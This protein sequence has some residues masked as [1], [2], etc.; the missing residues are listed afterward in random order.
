MK[1]WE[2]DDTNALRRGQ[3]ATQLELARRL[4]TFAQAPL[5]DERSAIMRDWVARFGFQPDNMSNQLEHLT[6]LIVSYGASNGGDYRRAVD[7]LHTKLLSPVEQWRA[8][9]RLADKPGSIAH[10]GRPVTPMAR[11]YGG[12]E[13]VPTRERRDQVR[14]PPPFQAAGRPADAALVRPKL[15][16]QSGTDHAPRNGGTARCC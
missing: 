15:P 8:H 10:R 4:L 3:A 1:Q 5:A 2:E 16:R 7:A 11:L 12:V 13:G 14:I 9:V 6:S